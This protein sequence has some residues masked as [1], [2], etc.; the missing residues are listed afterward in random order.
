MPEVSVIINCYNEGQ[1][2]RETLDSVFA[3]T[4]DD[5]E[6]VFWDNA[7]EDDSGEI[8]TS[9]GDRVRYFRSS[10]LT[11]QS[12]ARNKAFEKANGKYLA[13]LDAD[14]VWL[15]RKLERQ[16]ELMRAYPDVG[17]A[18]CDAIWF[19]GSGDHFRLFQV[20][21]PHRG[22]VF[23]E[24]IT[25]NF[26]YSSAMMFQ[27]KALEDLDYIFDERYVRAADYDL[28]LR[29]AYR[30]AVEYVDE[31][32]AKIRWFSLDVKP[33]KR[34][35]PPR[36]GQL[37]SV[38]ENLIV[39]HPDIP[40]KYGT[41]LQAFNKAMDYLSAIDAWQNKRGGEAR[42]YLAQYLPAKRFAFIYLCTFLVP[43]DLYEA[44][45]KAYR[46]AIT[47]RLAKNRN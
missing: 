4:F 18:Y 32:L 20:T 40:Q 2:V 29:M 44:L 21:R 24:L 41:Q 31:P 14:D 37:R 6:I 8:A 30:Y 46:G 3:Q 26:I 23:G 17:M 16:V 43:Y 28:S 45:R 42:R 5:W 15:P 22:H 19:D 34:A 33:W 47:G 36:V 25:E 12:I 13:I 7:S 1:F 38:M 10:T 39:T 11:L 27:R 9:Y 35:L